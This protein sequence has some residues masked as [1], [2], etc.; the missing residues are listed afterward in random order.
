VQL[1][2]YGFNVFL[3]DNNLDKQIGYGGL[4]YGIF[5]AI[6]HR[7]AFAADIFNDGRND[8]QWKAEING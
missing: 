8:D 1:T 4:Q 7:V 2:Q 6:T 3:A 5:S